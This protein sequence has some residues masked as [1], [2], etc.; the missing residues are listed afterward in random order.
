[1]N[2]FKVGQMSSAFSSGYLAEAIAF[3]NP[4]ASVNIV[5]GD[6][7]TISIDGDYPTVVGAYRSHQ[8]TSP[9]DLD[10]VAEAI[11]FANPSAVVTFHH[12]CITVVCSTAEIPVIVLGRHT[13]KLPSMFV[14]VGANRDIQFPNDPRETTRIF[15]ALLNEC[16]T[17]KTAL[18]LQ[19][20]PAILAGA[21][22]QLS[23]REECPMIYTTLNGNRAEE[24]QKPDFR[25]VGIYNIMNNEMVWE[26]E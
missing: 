15:K 18:L 26:L 25:L 14:Q 20:V 9:H 1:M 17:T 23:Q 22:V 3:V 8:F 10:V 5:D 2:E 7:R 13:Q 24:G 4:S 6:V 11:A 19:N 12:D 16:L 21:I